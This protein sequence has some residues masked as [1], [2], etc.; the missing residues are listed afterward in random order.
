MESKSQGKADPKL[1][2]FQSKAEHT[3]RRGIVDAVFSNESKQVLQF[4]SAINP[5]SSK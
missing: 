3:K 2:S 4:S 5:V 1:S